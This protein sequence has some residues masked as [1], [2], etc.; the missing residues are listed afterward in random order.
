VETHC[1]L[2][3]SVQTPLFAHLEL[4]VK[5]RHWGKGI[6]E[7]FLAEPVVNTAMSST[8]P[9]PCV[10][11]PSH[12]LRWGSAA[13]CCRDLS[14]IMDK[15][16]HWPPLHTTSVGVSSKNAT[17]TWENDTESVA[18]VR[19]GKPGS[20]VSVGASG[21]SWAKML[22]LQKPRHCAHREVAAADEHTRQIRSAQPR[23]SPRELPS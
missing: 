16:Q 2:P 5:L 21:A 20:K 17:L 23:S 13:P 19:S 9:P 15:K 11:P 18:N 12:D 6:K 14:S 10:C 22:Q 4:S 1:S 8:M 7:L 3:F